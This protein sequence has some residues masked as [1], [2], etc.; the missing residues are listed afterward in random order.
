MELADKIMWTKGLL[1]GCPARKALDNCP[2]KE[3]RNLPTEEG[4]KIVDEM[5]REEIESIIEH[6]RDCLTQKIYF[7]KK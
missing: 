6:H 4:M 1:V 3:L 5:K 7:K 2:I